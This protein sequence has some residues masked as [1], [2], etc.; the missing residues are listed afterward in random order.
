LS[1]ENN[2]FGIIDE[3]LAAIMFFLSLAFLALLAALIVLWIDVEPIAISEVPQPRAIGEVDSDVSQ[4]RVEIAASELAFQTSAKQAGSWCGLLLVLLWPVFWAEQLLHFTA[5]ENVGQF[6]RT[7]PYWWVYCLVPPLRL[8]ARRR[9]GN[10]QIWLPRLGF[11]DVDRNLRRRMERVFSIPM[12]WI[13][14]LILPVLGLHLIFKEN[15]ANY[16]WLRSLLHFSTGLIWFAFAV[17]FIVMVSIANKKLDYC[18]KHWLD[19]AIILL[20]LISFLRSLRVL[21]ASKLLKF[22]RLQQLSRVVRVYRLR[23]VAMRGLRALMLLE[24]LQR[25]M[26]VKPERRIQKLEELLEE[27]RHEIQELEHEIKKLKASLAEQGPDNS[28]QSSTDPIVTD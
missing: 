14:M 10:Q 15:I 16:P 25:L 5:A 1:S 3:T 2:R 6:K 17:E 28:S 24:V 9:Q 4:A 7:H 13:A 22:G 19:L 27:K 18:K 11:Q 12:I 8:C 23:G 20:P 26:R 21:R